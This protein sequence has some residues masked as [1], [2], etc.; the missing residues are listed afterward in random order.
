MIHEEYEITPE[1]HK[2]IV[3]L[4]TSDKVSDVSCRVGLF[5]EYSLTAG[6][7]KLGFTSTGTIGF[8]KYVL[9]V[10]FKDEGLYHKELKRNIGEEIYLLF[11]KAYRKHEEEQTRKYILTHDKKKKA[12]QEN[13]KKISENIK[14]FLANE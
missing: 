13:E 5:T 12:Q 8:P 11:D 9:R 4:I 10:S 7:Y 14:E 2:S 3:Q 1:L 6:D